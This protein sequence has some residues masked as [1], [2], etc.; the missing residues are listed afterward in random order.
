MNDQRNLPCVWMLSGLLAYRL[1][2]REYDCEHCELDAALAGKR[3]PVADPQVTESGR[4]EFP[5]KRDYHPAHAWVSNLED[6]HVRFGLDAFVAQL[7]DRVTGVVLP[8]TG[9]QMKQGHPACWLVDDGEPLPI[10]APVSGVVAGCNADVK[11]D[12]GLVTRSPYREGW[13]LELSCDAAPGGE[14]GLLSAE[15][16]RARSVHQQEELQALGAEA[17][18]VDAR[19]GVTLADGGTPSTDLRHA[20]GTHKY[21]AAIRTILRGRYD[22]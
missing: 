18:P 17:R 14:R 5:P 11:E 4:L 2:D 8:A 16:M 13:L 19:L 10:L 12:P 1:C 7:L 22:L 15:E 20:L 6:G 3:L 9:T 21:H